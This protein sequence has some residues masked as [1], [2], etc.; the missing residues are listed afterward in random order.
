MLF[1][2]ADDFKDVIA[3]LDYLF[4]MQTGE[5]MTVKENSITLVEAAF[6]EQLNHII[7][8]QAR[9]KIIPL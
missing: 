9:E 1:S 7:V 5:W 2:T 8:S 3:A 4:S 6:N